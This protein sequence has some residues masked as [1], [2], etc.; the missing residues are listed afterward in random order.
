VDVLLLEPLL[1]VILGIERLGIKRYFLLEV[2][3]IFGSISL[4]WLPIV[5]KVHLELLL[6]VR[7]VLF[8]IHEVLLIRRRLVVHLLH[9]IIERLLLGQDIAWWSLVVHLPVD[10]RKVL[11]VAIGT[12]HLVVWRRD[13]RLDLGAVHIDVVQVGT[14]SPRQHRISA[15]L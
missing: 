5:C 1:P 2:L 9:L 10:G 12:T 3:G 4:T 15:L 8:V 13:I 11:V 14:A 6:L 7:M